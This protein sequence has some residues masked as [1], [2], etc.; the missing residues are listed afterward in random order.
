MTPISNISIT[1]FIQYLGPDI[2][3]TRLSNTQTLASILPLYPYFCYTLQ[4]RHNDRD[5]LKS[6]AS[7]LFV[8]LFVQAQIKENI[9][10]PRR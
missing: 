4:W 2:S 5:G 1:S 8:Q 7:W 3:I 6:Q 10:I 9:K